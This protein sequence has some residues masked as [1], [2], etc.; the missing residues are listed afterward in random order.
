[1][2]DLIQETVRHALKP[3]PRRPT[4]HM[5]TSAVLPVVGAAG[6]QPT[7]QHATERIVPRDGCDR[8]D[9]RRIID[10]ASKE[11]G[12]RPSEMLTFRERSADES[13]PVGRSSRFFAT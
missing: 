9:E 11:R 7:G 3:G 13:P 5:M 8:S 2:R 12:K 10:R 6:A 1:M 4:A